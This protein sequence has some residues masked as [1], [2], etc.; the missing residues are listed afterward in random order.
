MGARLKTA[1][2]RE[3]E[4]VFPGLSCDL[5]TQKAKGVLKFSCRYLPDSGNLEHFTDHP[6]AISDSYEIEISFDE[7]DIFDLPIV[8]ETSNRIIDF[9]TSE[10]I[11]NIND[12]HLFKKKENCCL[13]IPADYKWKS[14]YCFILELVVPFFYWQSYMRENRESAWECYSHDKG[15]EEARGVHEAKLIPLEKQL[16]AEG[17]IGP[18]VPCPC[19]ST[20]KYKKCC[21]NK[22]DKLKLEIGDLK[23]AIGKIN[24]AIPT[25]NKKTP[26]QSDTASEL[27]SIVNPSP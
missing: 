9:A 3:I 17:K 24:R 16:T 27:T 15:L 6:D 12:L 18:N 22:D 21:R 13:G 11:D 23:L 25:S 19:N 10:G 26:A 20:K 5:A 8:Y 4:R 14:A 1:D 7:D 2:I